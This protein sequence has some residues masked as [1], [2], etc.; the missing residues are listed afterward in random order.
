M[1]ET[2]CFAK[3][4]NVNTKKQDELKKKSLFILSY[5]RNQENYNMAVIVCFLCIS[6]QADFLTKRR[7]VFVC[8]FSL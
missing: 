6:L 7:C 5:Q 8:V 4:D 1:D 2:N 3:S